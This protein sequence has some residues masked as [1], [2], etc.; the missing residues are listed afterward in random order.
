MQPKERLS[1]ELGEQIKP[2]WGQHW[3]IG[4]SPRINERGERR[5]SEHKPSSALTQC[6]QL[7]RDLA[8]IISGHGGL[9]RMLN[10]TNQNELLF[11]WVAFVKYFVPTP[12]EVTNTTY[13]LI[14]T[15]W[16]RTYFFP[17]WVTRK[18]PAEKS[19]NVENNTVMIITLCKPWW[20]FRLRS[21]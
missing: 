5:L 17:R 19:S 18:F 1:R 2:E 6:D 21:G 20:I 8:A 11:L 10:T 12:R 9:D 4:W 3:L 7:L 15:L 14:S 16:N 13:F